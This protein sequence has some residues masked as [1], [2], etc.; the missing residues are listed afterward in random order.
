MTAPTASGTLAQRP[1][2][3]LLL[4]VYERKLGGTLVLETAD[5]GKSAIAVVSGR[6]YKA[7]T[8][9]PVMYLGQALIRL[10]ALDEPTNERTL[11]L[12]GE[13]MVLHGRALVEE[14]V[15]DERTLA[16]G[17]R[18]QLRAQLSWM[19]TLPG[20][21]AFGYYD[22]VDFLA[23]WGGEGAPISP[24][25]TIW[26]GLCS[27]SDPA[28]VREAVARI[29]DRALKLRPEAPIAELH[30]APREQAVLD[31]LRSGEYSVASL[32]SKGLGTHA[33]VESTVYALLAMR[34]LDFGGP[35][36]VGAGEPPSSGRREPSSRQRRSL[37][38]E[39]VRPS[40]VPASRD[41]D[42]VFA[43]ARRE[44]EK[45]L[46][47]SEN[48]YYGLLGISSLATPQEIRAA[49]LA[50]A[51]KWHPDRLPGELGALKEGA[52]RLFAR[53]SEANRVLSDPALRVQHDV[54]R[55][56]GT[57]S[58]EEQ[59]K[60]AR[61]VRATTAFQKAEFWLKRHNVAE[62]E[63]EIEKA[64]EDDP[65]QVDYVALRA[66]IESQKPGA[67]LADL[68]TRLDGAVAREPNNIK[69][70]YY[71]GQLLKRAERLRAAMK[72]FRFVVELNPKHLDAVREVR[73]Y[74][75]RRHSTPPGK[76]SSKPPSA[77]PR[78]PGGKA[79]RP[80]E[81]S[82]SLFGRLFKR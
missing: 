59:E 21:G 49:F 60:V 81:K 3:Q 63:R 73:L 37:S 67:S 46:A 17:L 65:E 26:R 80:P 38:P 41:Q 45:R 11:A 24:L 61:V 28:S 40:V 52:T 9:E 19:L 71:R 30:L 25:P 55:A 32:L 66:W 39:K 57:E 47:L 76:T 68:I 31:T 53:I 43:A 6:P 78:P 51:K 13:R 22:G 8:A 12:A 18:E 10:G 48:E 79:A 29:A 16:R 62:A 15:V 2:G 1:L 42:P 69:A 7:R 56:R 20:E 82:S 34:H 58:A 64:L 14:G 35:A 75:M 72:D 54:A 33:E 44:L 50:S 27:K 36:P 70:R 77:H 74:E 4:Y 23:N 5:R